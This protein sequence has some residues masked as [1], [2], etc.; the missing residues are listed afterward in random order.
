MDDHVTV[1]SSKGVQ[2]VRREAWKLLAILALVV[3]VV[4]WYIYNRRV[5]L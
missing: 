5:Y 1:G 2:R 3:L 4:E